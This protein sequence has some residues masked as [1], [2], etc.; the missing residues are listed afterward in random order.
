MIILKLLNRNNLIV[1]IVS[2]LLFSTNIYGED[3]P[4]DIWDLEKQKLIRTINAHTKPI[5]NITFHDKKK[6]VS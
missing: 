3:E 6:D 1:L 2:I 5:Q 4:V